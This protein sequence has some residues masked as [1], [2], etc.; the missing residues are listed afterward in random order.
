VRRRPAPF[1]VDVALAVAVTAIVVWGCHSESNPSAG[2]AQML[3]GH[4]VVPPPAWAYLLIAAAGLALAWRRRRPRTV[5]GVSLAG[6]LGFTTLG[7]IGYAALIIPPIALYTVALTVTAG[8]AAVLA[9]ATLLGLGGVVVAGPDRISSGDIGLAG[10][11]AVA[12]LA[13]IAAANR[14]RYIEAVRARAELLER[15][16]QETTR[17]SVDAERLRIARELHDVVAHTMSTINVRAGVASY[18]TSDLPPP[19]AE[20]LQ[21]IKTA[22]KEGLRELRAILNV[23]RQADDPDLT[24]PQPG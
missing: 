10:L 13:G 20:A 18:V 11:V 21:A 2:A 4:V 12:V 24:Q 7:Y 15:T 9:L 6:V 5:L 8:E 23:L 3:R 17:R 14:R 16:Q 1:G 22:S 19:A